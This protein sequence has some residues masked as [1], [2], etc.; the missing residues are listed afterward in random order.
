MDIATILGIVSAFGLM[1]L[2]ILQGSGLNLFIDIPSVLI[3]VGGTIGATLI[4]FPLKEVLRA[5]KV[6]KNA[7]FNK[8]EIPTE[9][10]QLLVSF[11]ERARKEGILA[12]EAET[13]KIENPFLRKGLQM[14]VDGFEPKVIEATMGKEIDYLKERHK[15]G[16]DIFTTMG[17]FAPAMGMIGTLIGLVQMLQNMSDPSSI[18]P[19]M[20]VALITTFYGAVL[21][22]VLFLPISGKLQVLSQYECLIKEMILEG[23]LSISEG[24][25]PR[26]V[27]QKLH[28]FLEPRLR[29]LAERKRE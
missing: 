7:F 9:Y 18:G 15:L 28:V 25:N 16:A 20:A 27:E 29:E 8:L 26:I 6:A 23:I 11:A 17:T 21:A 22:N 10:V 3:V 2:A 5:I 13:E 1:V 19:A 24:L 4:D 12:L 14:L